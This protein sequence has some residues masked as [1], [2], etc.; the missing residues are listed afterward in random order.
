MILDRKRL[1]AVYFCIY[2]FD[3]YIFFIN[4]SEKTDFNNLFVPV[5][6]LSV[7]SPLSPPGHAH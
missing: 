4:K 2:I 5:S 7:S 1:Y 6:A 3:V